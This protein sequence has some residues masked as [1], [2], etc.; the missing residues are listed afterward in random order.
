M[1][2]DIKKIFAQAVNIIFPAKCVI[3]NSLTAEVMSLCTDCWKNIEFITDPQCG[4][5]G[6]PFDFD[7]GEGILCAT[8]NCTSPF[9]DKALSIFKYSNYSKSLIL[10]LKYNDQLHI[11]HFL[12]KLISE[13][14]HNLYE[15]RVIIPV[16]LH[17]KKMRK[18]LFNQSAII[19]SHVAKISKLDFLPNSLIKKRNDTPQN[20]LNRER[21]KTNILNSFS[22]AEESKK[23]IQGKNI[24]LIDDVYTTGST[25]N[26]CSKTLKKAGCGKILVAT[27]ARVTT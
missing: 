5:C 2:L 12:A 4:L 17:V 26:E 15:Y 1:Q 18:R 19:A 24:I 23:F 16:P 9:F 8:C 20:K 10:K 11:A 6:F 21:R 3:C 7:M 13:R 25:V 22:V 27:A 14:L